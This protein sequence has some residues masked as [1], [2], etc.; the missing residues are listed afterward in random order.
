MN[1]GCCEQIDQG[2]VFPTIEG[3]LAEGEERVDH[4]MFQSLPLLT[5]MDGFP[6]PPPP[7]WLV[8]YNY[9]ALFEKRTTGGTLVGIQSGKTRS[10]SVSSRRA[11]VG[12]GN[13]QRTQTVFA[14]FDDPEWELDENVSGD[15][16]VNN[17]EFSYTPIGYRWN[18]GEW[19]TVDPGEVV[20]GLNP[21]SGD[22]GN[23]TSKTAHALNGGIYHVIIR[24]PMTGTIDPHGILSVEGWDCDGIDLGTVV[25][26]IDEATLQLVVPRIVLSGEESQIVVPL[27][28]LPS[29]SSDG[30]QSASASYAIAV[31]QRSIA[32]C[33]KIATPA[34]L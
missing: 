27:P 14:D 3:T 8:A 29:L 16:P 33:R 11:W 32:H 23:K 15:D 12:D 4:P 13:G 24:G 25:E 17:G 6:D 1:C 31:H 22:G 5:E 21:A 2:N 7:G 30:L 10:A 18:S 9:T 28:D 34:I 20:T 26:I 19:A